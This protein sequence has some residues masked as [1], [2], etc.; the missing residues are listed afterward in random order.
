MSDARE[1]PGGL[2]LTPAERRELL[3]VLS[4]F[5]LAR[6]EHLAREPAVGEVGAAGNRIAAEVSTPIPE[7]PLP[8]GPARIVAL[9]ARAT[10]A[11][12]NP[13]GPGYLAY[14]PGGGLYASAVADFVAGTLNRFTGQSSAAPALSRLE[15]DVLAWLAAAFGYGPAARGV[16]TSGGSLANFAAI[17]AARH[18]RFGDSG[19]LRRAIAYV[20]GQ[21]HHSVTKALR[22]AGV[23]SRNVRVIDVDDAFRMIP[24]ALASRIAEDRAAGGEPFLVVAAAGTTNTG[25]VDPLPALAELSARERLW[26]HVDGAY[27]GAFVLCEEGR[28]ALV[29]IERADSITLDPHKGLFL[30]YGTGCLLARDG[31]ALRRAHHVGADYLQDF[32]ALDRDGEPPNPAEYG[33]ELSRDFRGLRLWLP[34]MLHGAGAFRRALAEKLALAQQACAGVE[35]LI[36]QGAP[37]ELVARPQLS[38][39]AFRLARAP[40]EAADAWRRRN[41]ALLARIV[42]RRRV[43]L[44]S[45]LLRSADGPAFTLRVCVLSFRTHARA[46]E[47]FLEDLAAAL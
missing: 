38:T 10:E 9:L 16:F 39:I 47:T 22:L 43:F 12:L 37:L 17:V 1:E 24:G 40:G 45:T 41:E 8:G 32:D 42:A 26:L 35:R 14:V 34:L 15:A 13:A 5:A 46:I 25:A 30:P 19:D 23:P 44:S 18:A 2:E 20:G 33:P 11:S 6:L 28:R 3:D 7:A 36:A 29:G 31:E 27:G 4:S 21:S